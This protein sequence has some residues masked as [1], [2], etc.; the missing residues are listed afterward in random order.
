MTM[1]RVTTTLSQRELIDYLDANGAVDVKIEVVEDNP[2]EDTPINLPR[3]RRKRRT[4][5]EMAAAEAS[6]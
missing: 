3:E 2:A 6:A 1:Y 5:A 4:K